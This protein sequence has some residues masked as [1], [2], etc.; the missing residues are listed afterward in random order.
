MDSSVKSDK[1]VY[2]PL[3][4][5]VDASMI[6]QTEKLEQHQFSIQMFDSIA[7]IPS[8]DWDAM[9]RDDYPFLKHRYLAA[10][11]HNRCVGEQV[12]WIPRH[13]CLYADAKLVAAMPLYEKYNSWGEFVFDHVWADAYR[14]HGL[15]YY[16]KLVN[17]IPFTP[18]TGQ[19][20]MSCRDGDFN[21]ASILLDS[22][23]SIM[24]HHGYSS[25]HCLFPDD[26]DRQH[27]HGHDVLLRNDC[28]F[29]WHNPGYTSFEHFLGE[30]KSKKRKNIR[31]ERRKV[32]QAGIGIR[33]LHGHQ[34]SERDW[35]D[36]HDVYT[37]IYQRKYGMPAFNLD[38]FLEIAQ[39][40]SD[41]IILALAD[42]EKSVVAGALLFRDEHVLYGRIW[43]TRKR[44]DSLHFELC[45]YAGI[46]YCIQE[47]LT[48]FDPGV[49]GEHKLARGFVPTQTHSLHWIAS[50]PFRSAIY[51][52]LGRERRGVYN[53]M[54]EAEGHSAYGSRTS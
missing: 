25:L 52:F 45:Y 34:T 40:M 24:C 30:L 49:Q 27:L 1:P 35:R 42:H 4:D 44:M 22:L 41:Q 2:T 29:Q 26:Q 28:H 53:Y 12:G 17:A 50:Q 31:H 46:E 33:W 20:V 39:T 5:I 11:E 10:L 47:G 54:N 9:L 13:V 14:H 16:P 36:F 19:R 51:E 21:G 8:K 43:G 18:A 32:Q 23:Q 38:F 7:A 48:R 15:Q 3:I 6:E 37:R